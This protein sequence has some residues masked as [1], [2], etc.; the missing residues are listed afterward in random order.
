MP[1]ILYF[2]TRYF[3]SISGAEFYLQRMAEIFNREFKYEVEIITSNAIDFKALRDPSGKIIHESDNYFNQV[4]QIQV[5]RFKTEYNIS[6][7]KKIKIIKDLGFYWALEIDDYSLKKFILNGPFFTTFFENLSHWKKQNYDLIHATFYPY[8]NLVLCLLLGKLLEIPTVCTPFFHFSNPRYLDKKMVSILEKFDFIIACTN[9]EKDKLM[10]FSSLSNQKIK[11]IPMGV[12]FEFFHEHLSSHP[13]SFKAKFFEKAARKNALILFCGYKNYEKGALSLLKA[14]PLILEKK[15][16]IN[17]VFI[18][19]PTLAFNR[20]LSKL[21]KEY[22]VNII[23]L[24]P[25]NLTGYYDEKKIAAFLESDIYAMPSRSDAYGIAF[26]EAWAC[27]KPVIG[28]NTGATPEVIEDNVD[29][30]LVQFDD[31]GDIAQKIVFLLK[32]KR[33]RKKMGQQGYNKVARGHSWRQIAI[34]TKYIYDMLLK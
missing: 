11:V 30:L 21:R 20:Q 16:A 22:K 13:F 9:L 34:Q 33:L 29:G 1:K 3:P 5:K 23:N 12:D 15:N 10:T 18:G 2:P 24:T 7:D 26:L 4:N 6:I 25:D 27:K 32:K 31:P 28:A 8:F 19:P 17:F 14:I